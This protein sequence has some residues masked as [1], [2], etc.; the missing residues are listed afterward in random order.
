MVP[1]PAPPFEMAI[2]QLVQD[3]M[4]QLSD[5]AHA[6]S[7]GVLFDAAVDRIREMLRMSPRNSG[8]PIRA[9]RGLGMT[10]YRIYYEQLIADYSVHDRIPMVVLWSL[11]PGPGHPLAEAPPNGQ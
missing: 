8:D 7:I 11:R 1:D 6:R 3:R 9:L 4:A 2:S 5:R 10:Q